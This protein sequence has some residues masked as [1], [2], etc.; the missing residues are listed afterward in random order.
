MTIGERIR[1]YRKAGN[2]TQKQLGELSGTSETTIK[3]YE[4]GKRQPR[5]DQLYKIAT[6]LNV[7]VENLITDRNYDTPPEISEN[8][9]VAFPGLEKKLSE[10][11]YYLRYGCDYP[12]S[13]ENAIWIDY[14]TGERVYV[15]I[16][17][18]EK[19]DSEVSSYLAF[20]VDRLKSRQ[21]VCGKTPDTPK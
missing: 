1:N 7:L 20:Q 2:L 12:G 10:L 6:A 14:P 16:A 5:V 8:H 21:D 4:T 11:G 17:I 9:P 15:S 3:Q 13:D 18:L 19:L